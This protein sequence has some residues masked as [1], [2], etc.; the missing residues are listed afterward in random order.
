MGF[1]LFDL[2][3]AFP[4]VRTAQKQFADDRT[5]KL[6]RS[7]TVILFLSAAVFIISRSFGTTIICLQEGVTT[8]PIEPKYVDGMCYAQ[9]MLKLNEFFLSPIKNKT[10]T[11]IS[12]S[13]PWMS[14]IAASMAILFYAPY[15]I[16]KYMVRYNAYQHIPI[17]INAVVSF[18]FVYRLSQF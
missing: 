17:D 14:L 13:Y 15:V 4:K 1:G 5:D 2:L 6:N 7:L 11:T 16:W 9:G 18:R 8:T 12:H 10:P 3:Q